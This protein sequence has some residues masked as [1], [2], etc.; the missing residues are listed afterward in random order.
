M[1]KEQALTWNE[2]V[3]LEPGLGQIHLDCRFADHRDPNGFD[4]DLAWNGT[5]DVPGLK[6]RLEHLVGARAER[7][8]ARILS[9]Q[10]YELAVTEC[11]QALPPNRPGDGHREQPDN[12]PGIS[13]Q[14][15]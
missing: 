6:H 1:D 9:L 13:G 15:P 3:R 7:Q 14:T 12:R 10:A 5:P 2:L 4:A 8:D 11:Y